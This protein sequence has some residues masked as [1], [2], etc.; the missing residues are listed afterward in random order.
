MYALVIR[1]IIECLACSGNVKQAIPAVLE[2]YRRT[3]NGV[4]TIVAS[5]GCTL[6]VVVLYSHCSWYEDMSRYIYLCFNCYISGTVGSRGGDSLS[7]CFVTTNC[8]TFTDN[9]FQPRQVLRQTL[10]DMHEGPRTPMTVGQ[11]WCTR[12]HA[13]VNC[14]CPLRVY[15][16]WTDRKD[17][18]PSI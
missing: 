6:M 3:F 9:L 2:I 17:T 11:V 5:V 4:G 10:G 12:F 1:G 15:I 13:V 16:H 18:E 8:R 7:A 14:P